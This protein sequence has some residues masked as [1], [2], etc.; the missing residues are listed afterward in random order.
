M[1]TDNGIHVFFA[2]L[3]NLLGHTLAE[4]LRVW[5]GLYNSGG[6]KEK[7]SQEKKKKKIPSIHL[8]VEKR[9]VRV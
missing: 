2:S 8:G 6:K 4:I 7:I 5:S 1:H 9:A 3:R